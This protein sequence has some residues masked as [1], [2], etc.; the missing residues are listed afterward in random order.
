MLPTNKLRNIIKDHD[1]IITT[2]LVEE[3]GIH[4]EYLNI[5]VEEGEIERIS[6]G[7]YISPD[8]WEDML[9]INQLKREKM[10]YSHETA[11]Y[12][13]DLTDR[14]PLHYVV[15]VPQGYNSSKLREEGFRVY[16]IKKEWFGLGIVTKKTVFGNEVKTY[17]MEKTICDILRGRNKIDATIIG[18]SLKRYFTRKDKDL[19][20]LMKYAKELR[21]ENIL[22]IGRASCRERV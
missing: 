14:D 10:I 4:R 9:Y 8:V 16:N 15:T 6:Q 2:N 21:I 7:I 20:K 3:K 22:K 1:G 11:L 12:L 19:N 18:D 13:H 17:D 5:L